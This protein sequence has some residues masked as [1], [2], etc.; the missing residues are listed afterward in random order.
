M[1]QTIF[2]MIMSR[3]RFIGLAILWLLP[4]A[5]QFHS[6][7]RQRLLIAGEAATSSRLLQLDHFIISQFSII[8]R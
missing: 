5:G 3:E 4:S 2:H 7:L 6:S 1:Q 8:R